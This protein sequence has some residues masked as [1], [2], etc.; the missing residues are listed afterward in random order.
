VAP[1]GQNAAMFEIDKCAVGAGAVVD[2][3]DGGPAMPVRL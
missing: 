3:A 2:L 1:G